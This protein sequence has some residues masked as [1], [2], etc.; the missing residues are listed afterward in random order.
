L[1]SPGSELVFDYI[2][3]SVLRLQDNHYGEKGAAQQMSKAGEQ[4]HFG[5]EEGEIKPFLE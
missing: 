4:W 3:A 1:A 2:Y 5:I